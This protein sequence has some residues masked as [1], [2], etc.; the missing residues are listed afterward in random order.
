MPKA[1]E[2]YVTMMKTSIAPGLRALGFKGSGQNYALPSSGYWALL[3][4]QKS[5][6]SDASEL[7]FTIN[8]LVVAREAWEA[9]KAER[10]EL[11]D[12]PTATTFWGDFVWQ[13]RI[14]R[15]LPGNEDLWWEL[16]ADSHTEELA[17]AVLWAVADYALPAMREQMT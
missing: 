17:S 3:G 13:R 14:G 11:R 10:P 2:T 5:S 7:R 6:F 1:Q 15:L 12:R 9:K 4:F 8:V 16:R